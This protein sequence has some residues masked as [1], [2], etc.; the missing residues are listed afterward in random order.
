[1]S[2]HPCE[3]IMFNE[4]G[5]KLPGI[6]GSPD[7]FNPHS[8]GQDAVIIVDDV[9]ATHPYWCC[10]RHLPTEYK[11]IL[12]L[13]V[14]RDLLSTL[15]AEYLSPLPSEHQLG[16]RVTGRTIEPLD[17]A[18]AFDV[19]PEEFWTG[20]VPTDERLLDVVYDILQVNL[21]HLDH[22]RQGTHLEHTDHE[23]YFNQHVKL[24]RGLLAEAQ[25]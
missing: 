18:K 23:S 4:K 21:A 11:R 6:P 16:D 2:T 20:K 12:R 19:S 7:E 24:L 25:Q 22:G 3:I 15:A 10:T 14:L 1:M 5:R 9:E 8:C 13:Q 17:I